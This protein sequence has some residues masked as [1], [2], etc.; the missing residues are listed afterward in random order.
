MLFYLFVEVLA[1]EDIGVGQ[2][3]DCRYLVIAECIAVRERRLAIVEKC[4]SLS[5]VIIV[6]SSE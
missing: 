2:R 5:L 1:L 6:L 4:D 3:D